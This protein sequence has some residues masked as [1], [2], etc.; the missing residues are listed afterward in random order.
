M[1]VLLIQLR[2]TSTATYRK[3]TFAVPKSDGLDVET[4]LSRDL[5]ETGDRKEGFKARL[6]DRDPEFKGP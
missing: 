5:Y 1:A 3:K 6:E 2:W 4:Y